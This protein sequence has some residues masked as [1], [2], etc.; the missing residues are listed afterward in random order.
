M[1][2]WDG[3]DKMN[4]DLQEGYNEQLAADFNWDGFLTE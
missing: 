4:D 3:R 1:P 2:V